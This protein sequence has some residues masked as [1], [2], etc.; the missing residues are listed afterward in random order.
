M[1]ERG[2]ARHPVRDA[3]LELSER[4]EQPLNSCALGGKRLGARRVGVL[5]GHRRCTSD[6]GGSL[7]GSSCC[8]WH[9][10]RRRGLAR[11]RI[12]G[13]RALARRV[14]RKWLWQRQR[15]AGARARRAAG[16]AH[17]AG[18]RA[19]GARSDAARR[20]RRRARGPH[21][22]RRRRWCLE[23]LGSGRGCSDASL[24]VSRRR[25]LAAVAPLGS[26][27]LVRA[28]GRRRL[29]LRR[30]ARRRV[31]RCAAMPTTVTLAHARAL[32]LG[33]GHGARSGLARRAGRRRRRAW[34]RR[35]DE[36]KVLRVLRARRR[37]A[38]Q[39]DR[40]ADRQAG[41]HDSETGRHESA[42]CAQ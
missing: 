14:G 2:R 37:R 25:D 28:R 16:S 30:T 13:R 10:D 5:R 36:L 42:A 35:R 24:R 39:A 7:V 17:G 15:S 41:R 26:I 18:A 19:Q 21:L 20:A 40:Q 34:R 11:S 29:R 32:R 8:G 4:A 9:A 22:R 27:G 31:I 33:R 23:G 12:S 38:V 6:G 3:A 1:A